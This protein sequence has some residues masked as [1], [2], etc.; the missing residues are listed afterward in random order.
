MRFTAGRTSSWAGDCF[1]YKG[2][3]E[4]ALDCYENV[5]ACVPEDAS[6]FDRRVVEANR[7]IILRTR[8]IRRPRRHSTG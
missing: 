4:L 3:F 5:L 8:L 7:A 6:S 1:R 2:Q